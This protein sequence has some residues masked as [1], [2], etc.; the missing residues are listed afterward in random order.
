MNISTKFNH[1][2]VRYIKPFPPIQKSRSWFYIYKKLLEKSRE[3]HNTSRSQPTT[4]RERERQNACKLNKQIHEQHIDHYADISVF[5]KLWCLS[6]IVF[7]ILSILFTN[8]IWKVFFFFFLS[9][10]KKDNA[11]KTRIP[12]G[13]WFNP[14]FPSGL[15]ILI[16]L[17]TFSFLFYFE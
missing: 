10:N 2:N 11:Y 3:C 17:C 8:L 1:Q 16:S 12:Y 6:I 13:I 14:H 5:I 7:Y 9:Y 15:D 4:P